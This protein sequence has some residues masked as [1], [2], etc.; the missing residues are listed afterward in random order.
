[1]GC[2]RSIK[3][4]T[5]KDCLPGSV[6]T[7]IDGPRGFLPRYLLAFGF[8][9]K[10]PTR[11][12]RHLNLSHSFKL[13][14]EPWGKKPS[15]FIS[16]TF[17]SHHWIS[18]LPSEVSIAASAVITQIR[19]C[20]WVPQTWKSTPPG[21]LNLQHRRSTVTRKS[22][23]PNASPNGMGRQP[24]PSH[25]AQT[26]P[27]STVCDR[28]QGVRLKI[29]FPIPMSNMARTDAHQRRSSRSR[30]QPGRQRTS[31]SRQSGAQ[32]LSHWRAA[33]LGARRRRWAWLQ[34]QYTFGSR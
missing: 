7:V 4:L 6:M 20:N 27:Y 28:T 15:C 2:K 30:N 17:F 24:Y 22:C 25:Q 10:Q 23:S 21:P 19:V 9:Q 34:P 18:F 29:A 14:T 3:S 13:T 26:N 1:M 31:I 32:A 16:L 33:A 5:P 11:P 8:T 12:F